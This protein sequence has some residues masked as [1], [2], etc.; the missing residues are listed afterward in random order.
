MELTLNDISIVIPTRQK[1]FKP[2]K[3]KCKE[4]IVIYDK[5]GN[6]S[7]ARNIG[8]KKASGKII[9]FLDDDVIP[10]KDFLVQGLRQFKDAD[11]G[12]SKVIGGIK[13]SKNKFT[14]TAC[15]FKKEVLRKVKGF[16]ERFKFFNEDIDIYLRCLK[17]GFKYKY[18]SKSIVYHPGKGTFEKL[19]EAN[20]LL[21]RKWP[22]YY[23]KLKKEV[24]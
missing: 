6:V 15:W 21:K 4:V 14:S 9:V 24:R 10:K 23:K 16:D 20:K 22:K 3:I 1:N 17:A 8:W 12:Q 13:N 7:K 19:L 11:F 5:V 2:Y 18:L